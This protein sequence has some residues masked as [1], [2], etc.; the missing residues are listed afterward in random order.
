MLRFFSYVS[1]NI[2]TIILSFDCYLFI[3]LRKKNSYVCKKLI[4]EFIVVVVVV[5]VVEKIGVKN[6]RDQIYGMC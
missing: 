5:L 1:R 2:S 6:D 4:L 3:S